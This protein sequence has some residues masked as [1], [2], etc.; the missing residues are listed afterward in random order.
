[1]AD[2]SEPGHRRPRRARR[3]VPRLRSDRGDRP[4][5]AVALGMTDAPRHHDADADADTQIDPVGDAEAELVVSPP[6]SEWPGRLLA[7]RIMV[8]AAIVGLVTSLVG[9]VVAWQL[10]GQLDENTGESL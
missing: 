3:P 9:T 4:A 6:R 7:G 10:L 8:G 2:G 1:D 5:R